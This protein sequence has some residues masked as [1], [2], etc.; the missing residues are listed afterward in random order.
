[1]AK[2]TYYS[3]NMKNIDQ[4]YQ[5]MIPNRTLPARIAHILREQILSGELSGGRS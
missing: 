3:E 1:M 2:K 5:T 4:K